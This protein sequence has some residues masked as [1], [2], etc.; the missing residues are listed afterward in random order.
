MAGIKA[1]LSAIPLVGNVIA[2]ELG[3]LLTPPLTR[4]R[5][6]FFEDAVRRLR[7]LEKRV[8]GFR[9]EDLAN[10][11]RF[12]SAMVQATQAALR[13]HQQEKLDALRNAVL[14]VALKKK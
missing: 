14:N 3:L 13:T 4:R 5:D 6:N 7:D 1:G 9:F 2:G 10:D 11:E 8:D 12:I